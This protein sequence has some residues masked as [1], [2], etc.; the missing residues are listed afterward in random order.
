LED[1]LVNTQDGIKTLH[2]ILENIQNEVVRTLMAEENS[3]YHYQ[4]INYSEAP[5]FFALAASAH[6]YR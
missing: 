2:G 5:S 4:E 6:S 3:L 1:I